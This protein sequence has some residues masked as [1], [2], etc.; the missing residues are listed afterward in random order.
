MSVVTVIIVLLLMLGIILPALANI[1]R[2]AYRASCAR[3]L[4]EIAMSMLAYANDYDGEFPR[5]GGTNS[6]WSKQ[7]PGW[8]AP[9]RFAAYGLAADGRGGVGN[10]SS[11]FYLL[12]KY[13]YPPPL[14][15]FVCRGDSG[16]TVFNPA[17]EGAGE[18]ELAE[19]WDFGSSPSKHCSYSY[20]QPFSLYR[21][22]TS[23]EP[24]MA[25]VADRNPFIQSPTRE[26]KDISLFVPEGGR[27]ALNMGNAYAHQ[28]AGQNV[29]F[30][31]MHVGFEKAPY[32]GVDDDNIYTFWDGGDIRRGALPT[33]ASES[34][35]RTDSLLVHDG[36]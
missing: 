8:M 7:I 13:S 6:R 23:S 36:H 12:I 5:S 25:V 33:L 27:A 17:D 3:N 30:L 20:H 18:K 35:D 29:L 22:T 21:L 16:T 4:S 24:G 14:K 19:L 2:N 26:P 11:C 1:R 32:C 9:N 31:D 10:I 28:N 34:Q 15:A